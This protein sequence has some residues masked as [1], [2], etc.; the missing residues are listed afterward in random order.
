MTVKLLGRHSFRKL[1]FDNVTVFY[2]IF[3]LPSADVSSRR[4][5]FPAVSV[6]RT[7]VRGSRTV[8][9]FLPKAVSV[10][11]SGRWGEEGKG[12]KFVTVNFIMFILIR[13]NKM[14][15]Y[16]GIYLLQNYSTCFGG[17]SQPSSGVHKTVTAA[18]GTGHNIRVTAFLQHDL[19]RPRWRKVVTHILWPVP[20]AAVTVLCTPD[21]VRWTPETCRVILR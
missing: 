14:Q 21:D 17:P 5:K 12:N 19:I 2:F 1:R 10:V 9:A 11:T 6:I 8:Q 15:Q 18:F 7:D 16:A 20:E 4:R 3:V 13:S